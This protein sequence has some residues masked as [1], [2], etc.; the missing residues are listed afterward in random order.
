MLGFPFN[1]L[2]SGAAEDKVLGRGLGWPERLRG[3]F[4]LPGSAWSH[5]A[6]VL[7]GKVLRHPLD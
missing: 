1:D 7:G 6:S 5:G 4:S 2:Y 3:S